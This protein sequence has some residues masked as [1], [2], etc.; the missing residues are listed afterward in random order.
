MIRELIYKINIL[1]QSLCIYFSLLIVCRNSLLS[2]SLLVSVQGKWIIAFK[3]NSMVPTDSLFSHLEKD[4][5]KAVGYNLFY[6]K[7][8]KCDI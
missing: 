8:R 4:I 3:F 5:P 7:T 6:F 1:N 2:V